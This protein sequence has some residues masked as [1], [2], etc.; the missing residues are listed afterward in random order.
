MTVVIWLSLSPDAFLARP[1][2]GLAGLAI[3]RT[4]AG[5]A[6]FVT[7]R[8]EGSGPIT[9]SAEGEAMLELFDERL[10]PVARSVTGSLTAN[11]VVGREYVL[12]VSATSGSSRLQTQASHAL[13]PSASALHNQ[14]LSTD[15]DFDG[16]TVPLDALLVINRLNAGR[17]GDQTLHF[18]DVNADR[19]VSPIDAL[20]IVNRLNQS[21]ASGEAAAE[22]PAEA[23]SAEAGPA[24]ES[25]PNGGEGEFIVAAGRGNSLGD[26]S[27]AAANLAAANLAAANAAAANLAATAPTGT[28][29]GAAPTKLGAQSDPLSAAFPWDAE[30][31]DWATWLA[32]GDS[33]SGRCGQSDSEA[34]SGAD[35]DPYATDVDAL[36]GVL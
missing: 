16:R 7:F 23:G 25:G 27:A 36:F 14:Y 19:S 34:A 6:T 15:V 13:V 5:E 4:A 10:M 26:Y 8:S 32:A 30:D 11:T 33:S 22:W 21:G 1:T 3:P 12:F 31:V 28:L 9:L 24:S 29:P 18:L 2:N 35:A 20:L 17:N